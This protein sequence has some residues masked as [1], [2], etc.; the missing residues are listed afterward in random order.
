MSRIEELL[1]VPPQV[2]KNSSALEA[3]SN[4]GT[5][6]FRKVSFGYSQD[7]PILHD[8]NLSIPCRRFGRACRRQRI[9]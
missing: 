3:P 1:A 5:I 8:I 6:E 4:V 2:K 7:Q 9:G